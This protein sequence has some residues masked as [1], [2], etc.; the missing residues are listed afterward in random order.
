MI[1]IIILVMV[2]FDVF[3]FINWELFSMICILVNVKTMKTL[4]TWN[5]HCLHQVMWKRPWHSYG[6][7]TP[8]I[9]HVYNNY[10]KHGFFWCVQFHQFSVYIKVRLAQTWQVPCAI[11]A[12]NLR[13]EDMVEDAATIRP[14]K[15]EHIKSTLFYIS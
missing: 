9:K 3:S 11:F 14:W 13:I 7:T 12:D 5:S 2:T 8:Q 15:V 6:Q 1:T 10:C 4:N